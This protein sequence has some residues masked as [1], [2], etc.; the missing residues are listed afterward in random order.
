MKPD[1][2]SLLSAFSHC[3]EMPEEKQLKG[4]KVQ[5]GS[6]F[7]RAQ[8]WSVSSIVQGPRAKQG[9]CHGAVEE[10]VGQPGTKEGQ[11]R[12]QDPSIPFERDPLIPSH[13]P[14]ST[15][16]SAASQKS[17]RQVSKPFTHFSR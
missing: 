16:G 8:P 14:R 1:S 11:G 9:G 5:L 10:T 17:C 3:D 7:H 6:Q 12:S 4:R 2:W 13:L 15:Q